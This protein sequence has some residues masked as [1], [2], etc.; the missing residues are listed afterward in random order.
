MGITDH[1]SYENLNNNVM[2]ELA[3]K[4]EIGI[5]KGF[6]RTPKVNDKTGVPHE[7]NPLNEIMTGAAVDI[8]V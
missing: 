5:S 8:T 3:N 4:V 2:T 1:P 7:S 6:T